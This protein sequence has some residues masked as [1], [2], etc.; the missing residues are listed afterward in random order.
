[1]TKPPSIREL[2]YRKVYTILNMG[3]IR[4]KSLLYK[5]QKICLVNEGYSTAAEPE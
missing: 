2:K 4:S 1:M 5:K 3:L